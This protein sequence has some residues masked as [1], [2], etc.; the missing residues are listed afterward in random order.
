MGEIK[1]YRKIDAVHPVMIAGWPGMGSVALGAVDYLR[2]KLNALK[3]AE[4]EVDRFAALDSVM[5]KNG[6][7]SLP[8]PPKNIFYYSKSLN[9]VIFE[10]AAQLPG[11]NGI[12]LLNQV[13][14]M[15]VKLNI[16]R[17]YTGAAF[18]MPISH[19][20]E[21]HIY[22]AA[23]KKGLIDF[24]KKFGISAMEEGHV[25][26]L[27]GIL[28]GLAKDRGLDAI[29]FL[30]TMPQYAISL[31]NPK[32]SG[33]IVKVLS[34]VLNFEIDT[35]EI[36]EYSKEMDR[37]MTAIEEKVKDVF[38]ESADEPESP[39]KDKKV[40]AYIMDRIEKLFIEARFDKTK[41]I[42]LKKE[43]D[44]WDLYR[45]HED[46]FLDLFKKTK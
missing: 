14:E 6:F 28:L 30:A 17:I 16:S 23:N 34:G 7:A 4:I 24:F 15:A 43:L 39:A 32:A 3:F 38:I 37:K 31:P 11:H 8:E 26:G 35:T 13:L 19:T 22:G 36:D 5:V 12:D 1:I 27:N 25:S 29:C 10:G 44:R 21:V 41:A 40:P 20:E 18:P 33:S 45:L 42:A 2:R 9:L 46:R